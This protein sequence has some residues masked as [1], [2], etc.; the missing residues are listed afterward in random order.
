MYLYQT[1][2]INYLNSPNGAVIIAIKGHL[3]GILGRS[4]E[5][6]R[7]FFAFFSPIE[8]AI[9]TTTP[10]KKVVFV[11][12][13]YF[14]CILYSR[15]AISALDQLFEVIVGRVGKSGEM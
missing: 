11:L 6:R 9:E 10:P 1:E 5:K 14:Q 12:C 2:V 3:I 7:Y 4:N 15:N 13:G 8:L